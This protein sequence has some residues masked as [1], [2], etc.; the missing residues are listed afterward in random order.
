LQEVA[1]APARRR[2]SG[3]QSTFQVWRWTSWHHWTTLA[4]L[5]HAFVA[6]ATAVERDA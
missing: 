2:L 5:A 3:P 4:M 1:D 6:A